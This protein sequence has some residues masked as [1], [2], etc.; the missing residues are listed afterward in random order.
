MILVCFRVAPAPP[1]KSADRA[2]PSRKRHDE[3]VVNISVRQ[4]RLGSLTGRLVHRISAEVD[5]PAI[6]IRSIHL[7]SQCQMHMI[8]K[9]NIRIRER[10]KARDPL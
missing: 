10:L 6:I 8:V 1:D 2:V 4:G 7:P 3:L 9:E 5:C